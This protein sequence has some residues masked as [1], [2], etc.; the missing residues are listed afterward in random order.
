MLFQHTFSKVI[1]SVTVE[2]ND[3]TILQ[4]DKDEAFKPGG[5]TPHMK[6]VGCSSEILN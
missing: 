3:E 6:G 5:G 1:L 2:D 4:T